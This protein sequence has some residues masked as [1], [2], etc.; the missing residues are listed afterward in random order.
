MPRISKVYF[1]FL[2]FK[3]SIVE[4]T[5]AGLP[6]ITFPGIS[7]LFVTMLPAPTMQS[8]PIVILPIIPF[9]PARYLHADASCVVKTTQSEIMQ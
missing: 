3:L 1:S 5:L 8:S 9:F 4:T 7:T 6:A 2:I